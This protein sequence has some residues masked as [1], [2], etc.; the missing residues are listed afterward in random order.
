VTVS[1]EKQLSINELPP[2]ER[3][4]KKNMILWGLWQ[5][6]GKPRFSTFFEIFTNDL[7]RLKYEGFTITNK[8][9]PKL[10]LSLSTTDLQGRHILCT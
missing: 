2:E 9:Q 1:A 10:M 5:G 7:I 3:F 6:K 4:A 8:C